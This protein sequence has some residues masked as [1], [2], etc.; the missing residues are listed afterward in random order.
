MMD[1]RQ[2]IE[3]WKN[4]IITDKEAE[5]LSEERMTIC[6][7]CEHKIEMMGM[8]VCGLCHCPLMASTRSPNKK[9]PA[10]KWKVFEP[11]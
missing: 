10:D 6:N 8:D 5:K 4:V 11:K 1:I 3:G 9:C 2:F 7:E